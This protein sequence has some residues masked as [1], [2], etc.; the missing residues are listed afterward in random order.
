MCVLRVIPLGVQPTTPTP[1]LQT[2]GVSRRFR[3][4][5]LLED[6]PQQ[7]VRGSVFGGFVSISLSVHVATR[8]R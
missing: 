3:G 4:V 5:S 7:G 8:A 6:T 2:G 1:Q